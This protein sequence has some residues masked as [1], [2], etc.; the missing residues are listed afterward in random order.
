[1][2]KD[3]TTFIDFVWT[4]IV[5]FVCDIY[6]YCT[7]VVVCRLLSLYTYELQTLFCTC[8]SEYA[9]VECVWGVC[10]CV[11][12]AGYHAGYHAD[13]IPLNYYNGLVMVLTEWLR[14]RRDQ[15]Q[16]RG[17]CAALEPTGLTVCGSD[18]FT[19]PSRLM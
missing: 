10:V 1:M 7:H 9:C 11:R 13:S 16:A 5:Q 6:N 19:I 17:Q 4:E 12:P 8:M 3:L 2:E 14:V 18:G 15:E